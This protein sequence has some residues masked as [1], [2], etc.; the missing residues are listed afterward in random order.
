MKRNFYNTRDSYIVYK[1]LSTDP[2]NINQYVQIINH[3]MKFLISKLFQ[4][5]EINI[6]ERL[7]KLNI[8]GKKVKVR[9]E[10]GEIKGLAPD[11]VKTKELWNSDSVAKN[12]KQ[13][14]YHFNEETNGIRY[15][16]FWSKNR[17]LVSNKTLY[18]L[19]M[20][21]TNKRRLSSLVKEGKEYL[22][23]N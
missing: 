19:R 1:N 17:V 2:I 9:I 23:K 6:P 14:V 20:T 12:N 13:L 3:F 18:N 16:F 8:I 10:D 21:R 22:I 4:T 7:G 11:W 15:K 5:G